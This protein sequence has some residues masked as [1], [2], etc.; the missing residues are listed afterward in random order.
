MMAHFN[1]LD[2][3]FF[4]MIGVSIILGI[5]KGLVRELFSLAFFIIAVILAFLFY[6]DLGQ[7]LFKS[8]QSQDIANFTAFICIFVTI[9]IVG[10]IITYAIK[11]LFVI[12]PLKSV[13]RI[14][15]GFFG[16]LRGFLLS[17]ILVFLLIVFPVRDT[18][19]KE[20]GLCPFIMKT[21]DIFLEA[22]PEEYRQKIDV[23]FNDDGQKDSRTSR[24]I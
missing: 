11:K 20:S 5:I 7:V 22:L 19:I 24:T 13:D 14:L 23:F 16:M 17:G 12:G 6:G 21:F 8:I 10:S 18:L 4:I 15:G 2:I 9:L 1:I 3:V